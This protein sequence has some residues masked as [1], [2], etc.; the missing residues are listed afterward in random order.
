MQLFWRIVDSNSRTLH[1]GALL[2]R[3]WDKAGRCCE[4]VQLRVNTTKRVLKAGRLVWSARNTTKVLKKG[5]AR[6]G[7]QVFIIRIESASVLLRVRGEN[8][9]WDS[10]Y[11]G[12]VRSRILVVIVFCFFRVSFSTV[13]SPFSVR[14]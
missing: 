4:G 13:L 14:S 7:S 12:T 10:G 5:F 3:V 1:S 2:C 6:G 8:H 9:D 11:R